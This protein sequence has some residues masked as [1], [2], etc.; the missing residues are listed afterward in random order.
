MF[1]VNYFM[2]ELCD[3]LLVD[4]SIKKAYIKNVFSF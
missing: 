1:I 2:I 4:I 3:L